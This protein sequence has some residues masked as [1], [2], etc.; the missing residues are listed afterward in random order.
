MA[1]ESTIF[2]GRS[3]E[4]VGELSDPTMPSNSRYRALA[5]TPSFL[6]D[7]DHPPCALAVH[8]LCRDC[9]R[10][11]PEQAVPLEV[12][13][14]GGS[15]LTVRLRDGQLLYRA[16]QHGDSVFAVR[17][18]L[19]KEV[20]PAGGAQRIVRL[21]GA[22]GVTGLAALVGAPHRHSAV[23]VG[24]GDGCRV[25][26]DHLRTALQRDASGLATLF[27]PWQ[28]ALDDIDLVIGRFACGP[29][30]SRLARYVLFMVER[31]SE[32]ARLR[33][34]DAAQLLGVT[35]VS[36]TRL[37]SRFKREGLI[38]ERAGRLIACDRVRLTQLAS[39]LRSEGPE[40]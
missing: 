36:V 23:V 24:D 3:P 19:V 7:A 27:A 29:A 17:R 14:L 16:D 15:A 13:R 35:P 2:C 12:D 21:V 34:R 22:G 9:A 31:Q 10:S 6:P 5:L 40:R 25:P 18:G 4:R 8:R 11:H 26:V 33:R 32:S 20:L 28:A 1:V 30:R 38:E 39:E 37:I